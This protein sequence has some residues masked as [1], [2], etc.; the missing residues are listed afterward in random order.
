LRVA[1]LIAAALAALLAG[2]ALAAD[3]P[4]GE[5]LTE[6]RDAR[7]RIA[8][9]EDRGDRLC[10][11]ITWAQR[12]PDA[13]EGPLL[14]R[15]NCDP[16]LRTRPIVGLPLLAGFAQDGEN[17]WGGGTI[18]DPRSGK[19]YKSRMRL[20]APDLLDVAGCILFLC[21]GETWTRYGP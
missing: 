1:V 2:N 3:G 10:G 13:P 15:N 21:K 19:T 9:C 8:P 11:T 14:D 17:H 18:Y 16:A 6:R 20:E 12:P 7:V 5:W 4:V